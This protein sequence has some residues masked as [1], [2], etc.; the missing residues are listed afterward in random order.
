MNNLHV[1][2]GDTAVV[3]SGKE[4]GKRGKVLSVDPK[5]GMVVIEGVNMV[6][7]HTKPRRQGETGGIIEREGAVRAC[8]V[9][10]RLPEVRQAD[11]SWRTSLLRTAR[12]SQCASTAARHFKKRR[13]Q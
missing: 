8:K 5:K 11:P 2:T 4:K 1:K 9:M 12:S 3:L 6:K 13:L 7:C 10:T